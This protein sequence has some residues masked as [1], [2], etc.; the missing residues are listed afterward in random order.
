MV[1]YVDGYRGFDE[2]IEKAK[3]PKNPP[4]ATTF[5]RLS[6]FRGGCKERVWVFWRGEINKLRYWLSI[7]VVYFG[8]GF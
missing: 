1:W 6:A 3:I 7:V 5:I 8:G 2:V 4:R